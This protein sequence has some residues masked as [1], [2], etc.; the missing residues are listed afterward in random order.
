M[1]LQNQQ[2]EVD[3]LSVEESTGISW[4]GGVWGG[5]CL[6]AVQTTEAWRKAEYCGKAGGMQKVPNM[7]CRRGQMY[8]HLPVQELGLWKRG[9]SPRLPLLSW[10][11]GWLQKERLW[12]GR[13]TKQ[14]K[15][16]FHRRARQTTF[17]AQPRDGRKIPISPV[18]LQRYTVLDGLTPGRCCVK[19]WYLVEKL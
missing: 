8:K 6:Q 19:S 12:E 13:Q 3:P 10:L 5:W 15:A 7:S 1:H 11:K 18:S 17:R 16:N 9:G 14:Q 2:G 4:G